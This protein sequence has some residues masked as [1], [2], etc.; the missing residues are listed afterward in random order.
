MAAQTC[1]T[2]GGR[3]AVA[4]AQT[5]SPELCPNCNGQGSIAVGTDDLPFWYPF[6][7]IGQTSLVVAGS[8]TANAVVTIDN[9]SDFMW[10]RIVGTSTGL[11]AVWL[12]DRFTA[13]PL[14]PQQNVP[15]Q[16][17]NIMGTGQL[18]FW[19]SKPYLLRRTSTVEGVF[20]DLSGASNTIQFCLMGYKVS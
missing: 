9:D 8:S 3:G 6:L 16:S 10:D 17:P 2:C 7:P 12:R 4:N 5:G 20:T 13:R 14:M 1:P 18:P 19:L 11:F 15:I